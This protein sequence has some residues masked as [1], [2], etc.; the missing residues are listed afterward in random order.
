MD[1]GCDIVLD[2]I[3]DARDLFCADDV[4]G[5]ERDP[6]VGSTEQDVDTEGVPTVGLDEVL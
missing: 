5:G 3:R 6:E 4:H 2:G 1:V